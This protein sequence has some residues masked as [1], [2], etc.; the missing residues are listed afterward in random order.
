MCPENIWLYSP[1]SLQLQS[2]CRW[3]LCTHWC[4]TLYIKACTSNECRWD[5]SRPLQRKPSQKRVF[6]INF[7]KTDKENPVEKLKPY[8]GVYQAGLRGED[9]ESFLQEI[10]NGL[11]NIY[12]QSV[13]YQT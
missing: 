1:S 5:R 2:R 7:Y 6:D 13:L 10:S 11:K 3:T 8:P 9:G 4:F 12:P